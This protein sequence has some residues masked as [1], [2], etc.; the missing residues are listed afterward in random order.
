MNIVDYSTQ[1]TLSTD[2]IKQTLLS[3]KSWE[4]KYRSLMLFGKKIAPYPVELQRQEFQ[5]QGCESNV[6]LQHEWKENRL[7]LAIGSDAKI[8]KGLIALVLAAFNQKPAD[9][10]KDFD[11][12][13][14]FAELSL[15]GQLSPS[16]TNGLH[17]IVTQVMALVANR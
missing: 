15:E 1:F 5:V 7:F 13:A 2:D 8:V 3:S 11:T 10:I 9:Q 16:R 17:A 6:W 12:Q 4:E 14:Y